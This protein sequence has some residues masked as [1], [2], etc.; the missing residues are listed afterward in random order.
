MPSYY[1]RVKGDLEEGRLAKSSDIQ[2]IQSGI[3]NAISRMIIDLY[4]QAFILGYDE[5]I[6]TL[7]ATPKHIDQSN[8]D[9]TPTKTKNRV[10]FHGRY[11]RQSIFIEKSEITSIKVL[12]SNDSDVPVTVQ[13]EI[14]DTDFNLKGEASYFL[15][16]R[17]K[18]K[19]E[20]F[21]EAIFNFNLTH[22]PVGHYYFVIRPIDLSEVDLK[23]YTI[24]NYIKPEMFC[25]KMD[26]KGSYAEGL[27]V[28]NDGSYY[29]NANILNEFITVGSNY[30]IQEIDK[31]NY[32]LYFEQ[33]FST[34]NTYVIEP[35]PAI[36]NGEKVY[37]LDTHVSIS[38]P[39]S[40][41]DRTDLVY[42]TADG[43][44]NVEEGKVYNKN[45]QSDDN[46]PKMDNVLKLAYITTYKNSAEQWS[47]PNCGHTNVGNIST[48]TQCG[49]EYI[50]NIPL[51]E[52]D[53]DN[54]VTRNRDVL[55]R[56][57]R[58]EKK[59]TYTMDRNS[60]SRIKYICTIDP[61]IKTADKND[62]E[63]TH[64]IVATQN[65]DGETIYVPQTGYNVK[66][67]YWSI[68]EQTG[69]QAKEINKT[70]KGTIT[71]YNVT[72]I[73]GTQTQY[74][75]NLK[76]P[77][78]MD[79]KPNEAIDITINGVKYT[80]T[81]NQNGDAALNINLQP[82]TYTATVSYGDAII[83]N[84]VTVLAEGS[85]L[86]EE[87]ST[88][89]SATN[90]TTRVSTTGVVIDG[91]VISNNVR[92]GDDSFY[93]DGVTVDTMNGVIELSKTEYGNIDSEKEKEKQE[94]Q[95][96]VKTTSLQNVKGAAYAKQTTYVMKKNDINTYNSEYPVLNFNIEHDCSVKSITP[97]ITL[98]R[99]LESFAMIIFK[100][101]V[102]FNQKEGM[103]YAYRKKFK[104]DPSFPNVFES[105]LISLKEAVQD[106][107][108]RR[109]DTPHSFDVTS[110]GQNL[111]LEAGQY[112]I[113]IYGNIEEGKDE[114]E[115][116]IN[117]Y[118]VNDASK[119][120]GCGEGVRC[121]GTVHPTILYLENSGV[122]GNTWDCIFEKKNDSYFDRG[123]I[124]S[125]GISMSGHIKTCSA[126]TNMEIPNGC[127]IT[128]YVSNNGGKTWVNASSGPITFAG[129]GNVFKWKYVLEG[130]GELSPKIK[131]NKDKMWA[132]VFNIGIASSVVQYEDYNACFETQL[133][134]AEYTTGFLLAQ[135]ITKH[136]SEWEFARI[137]MED[138]DK[139]STIDI[140]T[141]YD[142]TKMPLGMEKQVWPSTLFFSTIFADLK[143][144]DFQQTSVDYDNYSDKPE[145]DENNYR[146]DFDE[147][148]TYNL[149]V[150]EII[151]RGDDA[152]DINEGGLD[153]ITYK[154]QKTNVS[155]LYS[156]A[157][158]EVGY[159]ILKK[160][161]NKITADIK[162]EVIKMNVDYTEA[163]YTPKGNSEL[164]YAANG[165]NAD[166]QNFNYKDV[167]IGVP[168][169]FGFS[170]PTNHTNIVLD[171]FA[172]LKIKDSDKLNA[173]IP[174]KYYTDE[175]LTVEV[176]SAKD[177]LGA[178]IDPYVV[179]YIPAGT[180]EV[181]V[182]FNQNGQIDDNN[183]T[184][185]KA[186]T[187][188]QDIISSQYNT[189]NIDITD[190][191]YSYESV[192][193]IGIRF[194]NDAQANKTLRSVGEL[195]DSIGIGTIRLQGYNIRPIIPYATESQVKWT[196]VY[197]GDSFNGG[198]SKT[199][200]ESGV[201]K[202]IC[203]HEQYVAKGEGWE[204]YNQ[205][206]LPSYNT[207][208]KQKKTDF[209]E[210]GTP[211]VKHG[212]LNYY[213]YVTNNYHNNPKDVINTT[214]EIVTWKY[215][216]DGVTDSVQNRFDWGAT[217][218]DINTETGN[219]FKI[220]VDTPL[221]SYKTI[222][223]SYYIHT[224]VVDGKSENTASNSN[225]HYNKVTDETY[226]C[227][228][229]FD[230]GE[231]Y[232]DFYEDEELDKNSEP[233]ESFAL[234][235]WGRVCTQSDVYDKTITAFFKK[236]SGAKRVKWVVLRRE[237]PKKKTLQ[238][239]RLYLRN[240]VAYTNETHTS[241]G[242][243]LM[244]RIY[245]NSL[246]ATNIPKFRKYG[247]V[248]K[249]T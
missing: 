217:V 158:S 185:G 117:E 188:N 131:F 11:L 43:R 105:D 134:D 24:L 54:F 164:W 128:T 96:Y 205:V 123:I 155:Y 236:R 242:P 220:P 148:Y 18:R 203:Y 192:R 166:I 176:T 140:L 195:Q 113:L 85:T 222:L 171:V 36:I 230:K 154:Y 223:I 62:T 156:Q 34:G 115:I 168:F 3:Q 189:V 6:L 245:P 225:V 247:V 211:Y 118:A 44:V 125:Q 194:K 206:P 248:Y 4:G 186:Y 169:S 60:P 111:T 45:T 127:S 92:T 145:Y 9:F 136:F 12:L 46:Y 29:V 197:T 30:E 55:E 198:I 108:Y 233:V 129:T 14:R 57:R 157:G 184:Y 183:A 31:N 103:R 207:A 114:G 67:L 64:N 142:D 165:E 100:N 15:Q 27:Q 77:D 180:M 226:T 146:F 175:T 153:Y 50:Q 41:G 97:D 82:G 135:P 137:W 172:D 95:E 76:D 239:I 138:P 243:K 8:T 106:G 221:S 75:V 110:N 63:G 16:T 90:K 159:N 187:I 39:S 78:T 35:G 102:V 151:A 66:Q 109:L 47:C 238:P 174:K 193:S 37:P 144:A 209:N 58:L 215:T 65:G 72:K 178:T 87:T 179:R 86:P 101:D 22:L 40:L 116:I 163:V 177:L 228:G 124:I 202:E 149:N 19:D 5:D 56:I 201:Y 173:N 104:D 219:L 69:L 130:N 218:F 191:V 32:D 48:C 52:Q 51:I 93:K 227:L 126:S 224:S 181:V 141:S 161:N 182:A 112:S 133:I 167:I 99:N 13:A 1:N 231:F 23:D 107:E 91:K 170:I 214:N 150:G 121:L 33:Q 28:S 88:S 200:T 213:N 216:H 2:L 71:G 21:D 42:M 147:S 249:L 17:A 120:N 119:K 132:M 196:P 49:Y 229:S 61:I 38:G 232:I 81:T 139:K 25:A 74:I 10:S 98:F 246:N 190:E 79:P 244:M 70:I 73:Y 160:E 26:S 122:T 53:D 199:S 162:R 210:L 68:R 20:D 212:T 89:K 235:A 94:K 204:F 234:P 143:L 7:S 152:G 80:R 83:E 237:N 241:M 84:T 240:I 59:M 208:R